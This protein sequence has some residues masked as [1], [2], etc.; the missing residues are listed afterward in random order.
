MLRPYLKIWNW[1]LI[2]GRAVKPISSPG[3][4]SPCSVVYYWI[5]CYVLN[6]G[7]NNQNQTV[8]KLTLEIGFTFLKQVKIQRK[9]RQ[10]LNKL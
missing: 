3:V 1:D 6:I 7:L 10:L 9:V 2:F 5:T 4:H 8:G